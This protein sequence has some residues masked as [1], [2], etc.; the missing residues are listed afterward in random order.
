M[1]H[2]GAKMDEKESGDGKSIS[3]K[4]IHVPKQLLVLERVMLMYL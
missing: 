2:F 3:F 4:E 1:W